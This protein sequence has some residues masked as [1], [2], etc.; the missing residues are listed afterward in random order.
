MGF[1]HVLIGIGP[2]ANGSCWVFGL[3]PGR[4]GWCSP[5]PCNE[6]GFHLRRC[7]E[8]PKRPNEA[9]KIRMYSV[10]GIESIVLSWISLQNLYEMCAPWVFYYFS[11]WAF[12]IEEYQPV[13]VQSLGRPKATGIE[14]AS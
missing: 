5:Q 1:K 2:A 4:M 6:V 8:A 7:V 3:V 10:H 13:F 14:E 12:I 9:P 11:S